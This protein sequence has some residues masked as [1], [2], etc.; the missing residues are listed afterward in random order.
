RFSILPALTWEGMITLDIFE[1]SVNKERFI[2]YIRKDVAPLLNPF[3]GPR[4][5]VVLDNCAIHHDEEVRRI[6]EED[7][8]AI[9][10][11]F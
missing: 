9:K 11:I 7:C 1:G 10:H 6:I 4:S 3:P 8:G 5:V 2:N